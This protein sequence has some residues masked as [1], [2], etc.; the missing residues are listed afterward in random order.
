MTVN[1]WL[2]LAIYFAVLTALVPVLGGY[3]ARVYQGERLMLE[4]PLG[5]LERLI[6]RAI[7]PSTRTE[8]D[9]KSYGKTVVI[10]SAVFWVVLYVILRTQGIHPFN[11]EGF[12]SAP[13]DVT[14]NTTSSFVTNTNWQYYGGETTMTY[15]SQM[16]GLAVQ[17]FVSAAVGMAVL[18]A[19]IRGF[20]SRGV[21]ELGNFWRDVTRTLLYILL[22]LAAVGTLILVSQGVVQSLSGYVTIHGLGG[23]DQTLAMGPAASQIAIKQLG[24][25]GGG[26]FNLNSS[27]PFENPTQFSGF[28]EMIFILLIPAAATA[29]FGRMVGNRRQGWA[30]YATM[31]VFAI[32]LFGVAYAAEQN[33]SPAQHVAGEN[34][35]VADGTTGGNLEGKEQRNGI[36][37]TAEWANFTTDASNGSVNGAHDSLTGIGGLVPLTNMMTGEVIFGGVGS[38]AVRD[39]LNGSPGGVH[40]GPDGR[41]DARVSGQEGRVPGDEAGPD[42]AAVHP[43]GGT[44]CNRDRDLEQVRN[45]FDLQPGS[46]GLLGDALRLHLAGEQQRL[47]LCGLHG[48]RTAERSR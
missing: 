36:T 28:V 15:F 24:T 39:A 14:F 12:N 20:A 18:A 42:R 48:L 6:Y 17:N 47:R 46:A 45:A 5:W 22:P 7:G 2:Q 19:V 30:L 26:F 41:Q 21:K 32:S 10:F 13:W 31:V 34:T 1:G 4:R 37:A 3:M 29:Q 27:F 43:D 44:D 23:L 40:R 35:A 11:P 8:Q 9:W 16:A 33:G 38:W 25:N